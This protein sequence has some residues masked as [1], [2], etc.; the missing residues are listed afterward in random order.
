MIIIGIDPGKKGGFSI[1]KDNKLDFYTP[2]PKLYTD[3]MFLFEKYKDE[4]ELNHRIIHVYIEQAQYRPNQRGV[5]TTF[6]NY[7]RILGYLESLYIGYT[8]VS[9][10]KWKKKMNVTADKIAIINLVNNRYA[11]QLKKTE[12]GIAEAILIGEYG[13]G[14]MK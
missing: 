4:A 13:I 1:F 8:E 9:A 10:M 6:I 11:L 12:D 5:A 14:E 3:I 2:M 7:G